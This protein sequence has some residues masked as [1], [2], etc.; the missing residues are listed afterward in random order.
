MTRVSNRV[1]SIEVA[2][3]DDLST[4]VYILECDGGL[5]LIDV[6]FTPLCISNI[7]AE[8]VEMGKNWEDIKLILI[9]HAHGDHIENLPRVL[10]LIG[11][12]D[13][14]LGAGDVDSLKEQ[15]GV[16]ADMGLEHG[17]LISDCGGIEVVAVPGHSDGNLS[18]YLRDEKMMIVGDTIFGDDDGNLYPPPEKYSND[19]DLAAREIRK[20]LA[21]DFDKLLLSHGKNILKNAKGKVEELV[22]T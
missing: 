22:S 13:V 6:G 3:A 1:R 10:K 4:E 2:K 5:I 14:M 20:L 15:T 8:L 16:K 7:G 19:A 21:Y 17:D 12:P 11:S 9:T 18:F